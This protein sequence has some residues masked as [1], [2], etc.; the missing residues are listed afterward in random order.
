MKI[1][2]VPSVVVVGLAMLSNGRVDLN[3]YWR[4]RL[5]RTTPGNTK[6]T[7]EQ[8][9]EALL[10]ADLE[11]ELVKSVLSDA[12]LADAETS[13][14][15][16]DQLILFANRRAGAATAAKI[17]GDEL[18]SSTLLGHLAVAIDQLEQRR[19]D[20]AVVGDVESAHPGR[21]GA[22]LLMREEDLMRYEC[23][24]AYA[25]IRAQ[26]LTS[27]PR[28]MDD[29]GEL[30]RY[31]AAQ[32]N[33]S[34]RTVGMVVW[35]GA[36]ES[37]HGLA[38]VDLA[39]SRRG[40]PDC[41]FYSDDRDD[42]IEP[43]VDAIL[44]LASRTLPADTNAAATNQ[45]VE[46]GRQSEAPCLRAWL[47]PN[48]TLPRRA[49]LTT[50]PTPPRPGYGVLFE[51][52]QFRRRSVSAPLRWRV[53]LLAAESPEL[54][55]ARGK[56]LIEWLSSGGPTELAALGCD[57]ASNLGGD[58][59][60]S[61]LGEARAGVVAQDADDLL[62]KLMRLVQRIEQH[63]A[64]SLTGR[65]D[66]F[67]AFPSTSVRKKQLAML[68]P[69]H[70][71]SY[72]RMLV[73]LAAY[74][75]T[76]RRWLERVCRSASRARR[77]QII[78]I[79]QPTS[80]RD[81]LANRLRSVSDSTLAGFAVCLGL[82]QLW[83]T[84]GVSADVMVGH[85]SG[86]N[87][88]IIASG[89]WQCQ[90]VAAEVFG[91]LH[92]LQDQVAGLASEGQGCCVAVSGGPP[93]TELQALLPSGVHV[94]MDNC[95]HQVV[96]FAETVELAETATSVLRSHRAICI[97]LPFD[98]AYHT[99][100]LGVDRDQLR[101]IYD[102]LN[103]GP[104]DV[105]LYSCAD[106]MPFPLEA[107]S[108]RELA[109]SQWY[110]TVRFRETIQCLYDDGVRVFLEVGPAGNLT[111]FVT[112][113]LEGKAHTAIASNL[114]RASG[115]K[116]FLSAMAGLHVAG[117]TLNPKLL[118]S[119]PSSKLDRSREPHQAEPPRSAP[120]PL[121]PDIARLILD[122]HQQTMAL[123][124]RTQERIASRF[125]RPFAGS[126]E[127]RPDLSSAKTRCSV[128]GNV[129]R[130]GPDEVVYEAHCAQSDAFLDD[131][132]LG[133]LIA[134]T[135]K[136][137]PLAVLPF[138][139]ALEIMAQAAASI[140]ESGVLTS[141][142]QAR[143]RRWLAAERH[144]L[145]LL[146]TCRGHQE[147][148]FTVTL[149]EPADARDAFTAQ[150]N[151]SDRYPN[152]PRSTIRPEAL[153]R[154]QRS[155]A[156]YYAGGMFHQR[157]LRCVTEVRGVNQDH[158]LATLALTDGANAA[159]S[160]L[161]LPAIFLDG[162][163]QLAGI[164][165]AEH[166]DRYFGAF[167]FAIERVNLYAAGA[168]PSPIQC[169]GRLRFEHG[170]VHSDFEFVD[171]DSNLVAS[172]EGMQHRYFEYGERFYAALFNGALLSV[173]VESN[174]GAARRLHMQ[175]IPIVRSGG[176]IWRQA[177]MHLMLSAGERQRVSSDQMLFGLIVAKETA[178][179]W[180]RREK[181]IDFHPAEIELSVVDAEHGLIAY[182]VG[183]VFQMI[184]EIRV[185]QSDQAWTAQLVA[186]PT[187]AKTG[188]V[189]V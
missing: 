126:S 68:F 31:F 106:A 128:L 69:G 39:L 188:E 38:E 67:Y 19:I 184:A 119:D 110:Q 64:R 74:A 151:F 95:P 81:G 175:E 3:D 49:L 146:A 130:D 182:P 143:G 1:T 18:H 155:A 156:E 73:D 43:F 59:S 109:C 46:N 9:G 82:Q 166:I 116:Q 127:T 79:L 80:D 183:T 10:E 165:L 178:C 189:N 85:S 28:E 186:K 61:R 173:P 137:Q 157:S 93:P 32:S 29:V 8:L 111:S 55:I 65:D 131:H 51:D 132:R 50:P 47:H 89:V 2:S 118:R 185:Q 23:A 33:V 107:Q 62:T 94:A 177:L 167:P 16:S 98:K 77:D 163:G 22:V 101:R 134:S 99:P 41:A 72:G 152:R 34:L 180:L 30:L 12:N 124:S 100:A 76:L 147:S 88:A 11:A 27:I 21:G 125:T 136:T 6:A 45:E 138:S 97:P 144:Q 25:V 148:A 162:A 35:S 70:G 42:S 78:G 112:D 179:S 91:V 169:A 44:S 56:E 5:Y 142:T 133:R 63:P 60:G 102:D 84:L 164:W 181:N 145:P 87:A 86:E 174:D 48:R 104:G 13:L 171:A 120:S 187:Y 123:I 154:T 7:T 161:L 71:S 108:I 158:I 122:E 141:I 66:C 140:M 57:L 168:G 96:L 129:V 150:A 75:P 4:N 52:P 17:V 153:Q 117:V 160:G 37:Q 36:F 172:I 115:L 159:A 15:R 14:L 139:F 90:D 83:K 114:P 26:P 20:I 58:L 135:P 103:V 40:E 113:T 24:E 176:G 53:Y 92:R 105:P 54:L 170:V 121:A 149:S